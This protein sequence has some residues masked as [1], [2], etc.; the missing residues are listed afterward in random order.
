MNIAVTFLIQSG[1]VLLLYKEMRGYHVAPGGKVEEDETLQAAAKREFLEETNLVIEPK[2][3][4][5][6][7][8]TTKDEQNITKSFYT[9]FT[10]Y[11]T[12]A[13]GT[14]LEKSRE[15]VN[16]WRALTAIEDLPMFAGDKMLLQRLLGKL[17]ADD[18]RLD[19]A[20]FCYDT[21]Y[22]KL[23]SFDLTI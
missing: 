7:T 11:A 21:S 15:G 8:I 9:L 1:Q 10:F 6:S 5:I 18:M 13:T 17:S 4:A 14:L 12:E 19:Y 22:K 16:T 2:L 20:C 3:A 23:L